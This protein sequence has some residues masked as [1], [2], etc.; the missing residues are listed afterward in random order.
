MLTWINNHRILLLDSLNIETKQFWLR[1]IEVVDVDEPYAITD[2]DL[3]SVSIAPVIA[4]I[5]VSNLT[6]GN[7]LPI[8]VVGVIVLAF[9]PS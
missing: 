8:K 3:N 7:S 2:F 4:A 6:P 1:S 9:E 5:V